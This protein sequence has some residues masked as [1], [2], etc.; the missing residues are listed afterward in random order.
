MISLLKRSMN[1]K[2]TFLLKDFISSNGFQ[3]ISDCFIKCES[4][5]Y[6]DITSMKKYLDLLSSL[7]FIG[8]KD[9]IV[10]EEFNSAQDMKVKGKTIRNVVAFQSLANTFLNS[11]NTMIQKEIIEQILYVFAENSSNYP[12][13][14][15][16][17]III[18]FLKNL[19]QVNEDVQSSILKLF[20]F[21]VAGLNFQKFHEE[22]LTLT[23]IIS[24]DGISGNLIHMILSTILKL[25]KFD[26]FYKKRFRETKLIETLLQL[27]SNKFKNVKDIPNGKT[28][29]NVSE[30]LVDVLTS[31]MSFNQENCQYFRKC[32][33]VQILED[34]LSIDSFLRGQA[35]R[36][37]QALI[38]EDKLQNEKELFILIEK[39][40]T[41]SK[42]DFQL[43]I[44]L[45]DTFKRIFSVN[46]RSRD[47]F[48]KEGGFVAT[49]SVLINTQF[50]KKDSKKLLNL[51]NSLFRALAAALS[52]HQ[53]NKQLF[54]EVVGKTAITDALRI[55]G[56]LDSEH[57]ISS[58]QLLF[59]FATERSLRTTEE[60]KFDE[61]SIPK[62]P[63]VSN[64]N[65]I[66][67]ILK[68]LDPKNL[69][70]SK[71]ILNILIYMAE[72]SE[73]NLQSFSTIGIAKYLMLNHEKDFSDPN[74]K[75]HKEVLKLFELLATYRIK[76][77]EWRLFFRMSNQLK[78][79][80]HLIELL[81]KISKKGNSNP[82]VEFEPHSSS[83]IFSL[84]EK[85]WSQSTGYTFSSWIYYTSTKEKTDDLVLLNISSEKSLLDITINPQQ[86]LY[87]TT[88]QGNVELF[89]K[90]KLIQ[91]TWNHI[92]ITH[93]KTKNKNKVFIYLNGLPME[94]RTVPFVLPATGKSRGVLAHNNSNSENWKIGNTFLYDDCL[95]EDIISMIYVASSSYNGNFV[96]YWFRE[97][98]LLSPQMNSYYLK[99]LKRL[100]N[101]VYIA[102]RTDIDRIMK[103]IP[104][105]LNEKQ[106]IFS[107]SSNMTLVQEIDGKDKEFEGIS[108]SNGIF[109]LNSTSSNSLPFALLKGNA[110]CCTPRSLTESLLY[111]DG[112]LAIMALIENSDSSDY[113]SSSL[114]LLSQLLR[115][116]MFTTEF[117]RHDGY[118]ILI[119]I[120]KSKSNLI[121]S[122]VLKAMISI[123]MGGDE[124]II[125][126][127]K[128]LLY[129]MADYELWR[130]TPIEIQQELFTTLLNL[131]N[132]Q[133][134]GSWNIFRL[135]QINFVQ[136]IIHII[137][138]ES[139]SIEII[140]YM[141]PLLTDIL[142]HETS[143]FDIKSITDFIICTIEGYLSGKTLPSE[144]FKTDHSMT[145][146]TARNLILK[147]IYDLISNQNFRDVFVKNV[148][149]KWFYHFPLRKVHPISFLL[150]IQILCKILLFGGYS[151]FKN[152]GIISSWK[153][154]I[155]Y[156]CNQNDLSFILLSAMT[157][158]GVTF[159][160]PFK[161]KDLLISNTSEIPLPFSQIL[162]LIFS[163][164]KDDYN[165][166]ENAEFESVSLYEY[167]KDSE[168]GESKKQNII[169]NLIKGVFGDEVEEEGNI[170]EETNYNDI[171]TI[172]YL[173]KSSG[174]DLKSSRKNLTPALHKEIISFLLKLFD[175]SN[176]Y[177][178]EC[179]KIEVLEEFVE[180]LFIHSVNSNQLDTTSQTSQDI[181][182]LLKKIMIHE[183]SSSKSIKLLED[184]LECYP[185]S[186]EDYKNKYQEVILMNLLKH[187]ET[188]L[189]E[190]VKDSKTFVNLTNFCHILVDKYTIIDNKIIIQFISQMLSEFNSYIS[191]IKKVI[192]FE[193]LMSQMNIQG[194]Y[195]A[196]NRIIIKLLSDKISNTKQLEQ[197]F[198]EFENWLL[199]SLN[200]I[201]KDT[202]YLYS[203]SYLLFSLFNS[204]SK[205]I[206]DKVYTFWKLII[207]S[208]PSVYPQLLSLKNNKGE[209]EDLS[210][211]F[212]KILEKDGGSFGSWLSD[213]KD[214]IK[215]LFDSNYLPT[216]QNFLNNEKERR[217]IIKR[218]KLVP[219]ASGG[220]SKVVNNLFSYQKN[221]EQI[222]YTT[223]EVQ[224]IIIFEEQKR[225]E[226]RDRDSIKTRNSVE[227][228]RNLKESL[229]KERSL[230]SSKE[231]IS[232]YKWKLDQ[233]EGPLRKRLKIVPFKDN[234]VY[235]KN[236]INKI[237]EKEPKTPNKKKSTIEDMNKLQTPKVHQRVLS[238]SFI[239]DDE[240]LLDKKI[241]PEKEE[242]K[243]EKREFAQVDLTIEDDD[244]NEV[245][246]NNDEDLEGTHKIKRC[247]EIGDTVKTWHNCLRVS[248]L[249][250]QKGLF[251]LCKNNI[252]II[253]NYNLSKDEELVEIDGS[254]SVTVQYSPD[255]DS[256]GKTLPHTV[257]KISYEEI[258]NV[259]KRRF[260]LSECAL[261]I[262]CKD[263]SN[264]MIVF[265]KGIMEKVFSLQELQS[266]HKMKKPK[267][268]ME[269]WQRGEISNFSYLMYLNTLAG[270][271][272]NDLTQYPVFPWILS[273]YQSQTID[274]N[275][276]KIY[277]D[278][279]RPMG[280]LTEKGREYYKQR[281]DSWEHDSIPKF[282]YGTH[283]S[284][285]GGTL[286]YLMR[287]E[288]FTSHYIELQ[289]G[290]FDVSDRMFHSIKE[291]WFASSSDNTVSDVKELIPEFFYLPEFLINTNNLQ[292]GMKQNKEIVGDVILPPWANNDPYEFI[293]IHRKALESDYVSE[294]IHEWIDLVFGYKQTG[295]AAEDALNVFYYL[296]YEGAVDVD[297]ITNEMLKR[298]TISQISNFGQTPHQLFSKP[299]PKRL[300]K[301][302]P[303]LLTIYNY[304]DEMINV[305]AKKY[306]KTI[307]YINFK[308]GKDLLTIGQKSLLIKPLCE[309]YF[310][311]GHS[312]NSLRLYSFI[313]DQ[314]QA[315]W[316]NLHLS[317]ITCAHITK[318]GRLVLGGDDAVVSVWK[319]KQSKKT[320]QLH[321]LSRLCSHSKSISCV[322]VSSKYGIIVSGSKDKTC[323]IWD[324]NKLQIIRQLIPTNK[325]QSQSFNIVYINNDNGNII[326]STGTILYIWTING[327][328]I[329]EIDTGRSPIYSIVM[330][331]QTFDENNAIITG[332]KNGSLK[333][334]QLNYQK[335]KE[336][337]L[338]ITFKL[339]QEKNVHKT[340]ITC[341]YITK[342]Q[343]VLY[344]GDE[345]GNLL[346]W[347]IPEN[348][349]YYFIDQD[350][351]D[352][353]QKCNV[354]FSTLKRKYNCSSCGR[355]VCND[356][357]NSKIELPQL[358]YLK[359]VRVCDDCYELNLQKKQL[360]QKK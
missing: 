346:K 28:I 354:K 71:T 351:V 88:G 223:N 210:K 285:A 101:I 209:I 172:K 162:T 347:E 189:K 314:L 111:F 168:K 186:G 100:G 323:I 150:S 341:L 113:L 165:V 20:E 337:Q 277:R 90:I 125:A 216:Y 253:D 332:H 73:K 31:L 292:L 278:L 173:Q 26:D 46:D 94:S 358:H 131:L 102:K 83:Q 176:D 24:S 234:I 309:F 97:M 184:L 244:I 194:C 344:S 19:D 42:T 62:I 164:I 356:C 122:K 143:D 35:L 298:A 357:S 89:S 40:Q 334:W 257:I 98:N 228:W 52:N 29:E 47:T 326:A 181:F 45:F 203:L 215:G 188:K 160:T 76:E 147:L 267:E 247:L 204:E 61:I 185:E 279:S 207:I 359:P 274:L 14:H 319:F 205:I 331:N 79:P 227:K 282:H 312:D 48:R 104:N 260:L 84:P 144:S 345:N 289:D 284:S 311:Y 178:L 152:S 151:E 196:L 294:H 333:I 327:H 293:R 197:L 169:Q 229:I 96:G 200:P 158:R 218:T 295:K 80:L 177:K 302:E 121:N 212:S 106:Y 50:D 307:S 336:N 240:I 41:S 36:V 39:L 32:G 268:V 342:N 308:N 221:E 261:E 138:N 67:Y 141:V 193:T 224:K 322:A 198:E 18:I 299:H 68:I 30:V 17:H 3:C 258:E 259:L 339:K 283:Y 242:K 110:F 232:K 171:N 117:D 355:V 118:L 280:A 192:S 236:S 328:L 135:K 167:F 272:Y 250:G 103:I 7:V 124:N 128:G 126:N 320:L 352:N 44:E 353:C 2:N 129:F 340:G 206:Q 127:T 25:I 155:R 115:N 220:L 338:K 142:E 233:T 63:R 8:E 99:L 329:S 271:T 87:M 262:F 269:Q 241:T 190:Y 148:P 153:K 55:C 13:V 214:K 316:E 133:S 120:L 170:K 255:T 56:I 140:D 49:I 195:K 139:P 64:P 183:F 175:V 270:R 318:E 335:E 276:P 136:L 85:L 112:L 9:L 74:S 119:N 249:D 59:D 137:L 182:E 230:F 123:T 360:S 296:T 349:T 166:S 78:D 116:P 313:G 199:V 86:G 297:S 51:M 321:L 43:K 225:I 4:E 93:S 69:S 251:V 330:T 159:N 243:N 180:L 149:L 343:K 179:K 23:V 237:E 156:Y 252:Y 146:I 157:G 81:T 6:T 95:T 75:F 238:K 187:Y 305:E 34:F 1:K 163:I 287:L 235:P 10:S 211:G 22:L 132:D 114:H 33:G 239:D 53:I 57:L 5:F 27:L 254:H 300:F 208:C 222:S 92:A 286:Y 174:T 256:K 202:E 134:Y 273:D 226:R 82:F 231:E 263:G 108:T 266:N 306:P 109:L 37:F 301:S 15:H 191:S 107:F 245:L 21:I 16:L 291:A 130:K 275:D 77:K 11:K 290:K 54:S 217:K 304:P 315:T 12:L 310:S 246:F 60:V 281:Y 219:V 288:P 317:Q 324:L 161:V 145:K 325:D 105:F 154:I 348:P 265:E 201:N 213:N 72:A 264:F 248:G 65:A 38:A 70:F 303:K 58:F 66:K 91:G 350:K